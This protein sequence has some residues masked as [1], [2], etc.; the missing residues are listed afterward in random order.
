MVLT[1]IINIKISKAAIELI[2]CRLLD[3][4]FKKFMRIVGMPIKIQLD[5]LGQIEIWIIAI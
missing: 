3:P 2:A 1:V 5:Y 4:P